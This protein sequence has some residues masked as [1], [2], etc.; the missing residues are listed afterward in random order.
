MTTANAA[1]PEV[2]AQ[3]GRALVDAG[4][5]L[6][7]VREHDEWTAGHATGAQFVP[8]GEV[9]RRLTELERE[10]RVVVMCRSGQRSARATAFLRVQGFDAVNL[11]GGMRAWA[12]AGLD[13]V[14]DDGAP[15]TVI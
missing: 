15:G 3:E 14:T 13:V 5:T 7:D 9:D 11:A 8:L 12:T 1:V 6:L 4:A 10:R 2:S